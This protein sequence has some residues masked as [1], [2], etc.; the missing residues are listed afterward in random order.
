MIANLIFYHWLQMSTL[1]IHEFSRLVMK[2]ARGRITQEV[3]DGEG[4][5]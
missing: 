3:G 4:E 5:I 2:S 1:K